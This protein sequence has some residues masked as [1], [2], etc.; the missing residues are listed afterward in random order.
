[1]T[2]TVLPSAAATVSLA[3]LVVT[4]TS[5]IPGR[6]WIARSTSAMPAPAG[7]MTLLFPYDISKVPPK[8]DRDHI[9]MIWTS[10]CG[11]SGT[12]LPNSS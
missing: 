6:V 10:D 11:P 12:P 2:A 4:V 1:M 7:K 8:G 3:A 5:P 9:S